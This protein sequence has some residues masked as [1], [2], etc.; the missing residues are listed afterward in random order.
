MY[1]KNIVAI[2]P[3]WNEPLGLIQKFLSGIKRV[4]SI[5]AEKEIGFRH[6]FLDD[7]ALHLPDECS[8]LVRHKENLRLA[9]TLVDG[10]EA[11]LNLKSVPDLVIRLDCQEHDPEKIPFV[12]DHF[13]HAS[14]L[15][16][17]FLP[18]WYWVKGED[19]PLMKDITMMITKFISGISPVNRQAVLEVYNQKFP[20]GYQAFRIAALRK[21]MN[22]L[23]KGLVLFQQ[24]FN[25]S[26]S[27]GL[28]LLVILLAAK[29]YPEGVDFIFGGWS[30]PWQENRSPE[31]IDAQRVKAEAMV[32]L[33]EEL[34][35]Q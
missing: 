17:L 8:I 10:Y 12:I 1:L 19:R 15:Q 26:A 23:K 20:L 33:A 29:E 3:V 4:R 30:E 14:Q 13:S 7:G 31:K 22:P 2:T 5:L 35:Y 9:K 27:W 24:K 21:L 6:F 28:D 25:T 34:D 32:E 16:A 18:V 11:V